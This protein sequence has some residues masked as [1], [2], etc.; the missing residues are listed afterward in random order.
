MGN[1][2]NHGSKHG[3]FKING[4]SLNSTFKVTQKCFMLKVKE[5]HLWPFRKNFQKHPTDK[6][7]HIFQEIVK[8]KPKILLFRGFFLFFSAANW[9]KLWQTQMFQKFLTEQPKISRFYALLCWIE[10]SRNYKWELF[11]HSNDWPLCGQKIVKK[12]E[13]FLNP[14]LSTTEKGMFFAHS[15]EKNQI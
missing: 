15:E 1:C 5:K 10:T 13:K 3:F 11:Y 14:T 2:S 9:T 12:D 7:T 6:T 4:N 8:N